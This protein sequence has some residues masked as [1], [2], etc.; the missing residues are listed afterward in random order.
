MKS[1]EYKKWLFQK[2]ASRAYINQGF[3]EQ[4]FIFQ[5]SNMILKLCIFLAQTFA[6]IRGEH[7]LLSAMKHKKNGAFGFVGLKERLNGSLD[8]IENVLGHKV[9]FNDSI[10]SFDNISYKYLTECDV[11]MPLNKFLFTTTNLYDHNTYRWVTV[12]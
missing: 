8:Y 3:W 2:K 11:K 9:K 6:I 10:H 4:P 7:P 5:P 12:Q 1:I